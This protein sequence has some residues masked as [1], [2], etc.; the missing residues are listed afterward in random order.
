MET[1]LKNV[2][3]IPSWYPTKDQPYL[4]VFFKEQ[5]YL[6]SENFNICV[7]NGK[8]QLIGRKKF[9]TNLFTK[10]K[11]YSNPIQVENNNN[12]YKEFEFKYPLYVFRTEKQQL[13]QTVKFYQQALENLEFS[14]DLIHA[15]SNLMAGIIASEITNKSNCKLLITE[16]LPLILNNFNY[17]LKE[18][19]FNAL[20]KANCVS[21]VS[22]H[23]RALLI[24]NIPKTEVVNHGNLIDENL[25]TLKKELD[26]SIYKIGWVGS[27]YYRK[28]PFT[29]LR[30]VKAIQRK[31]ISCHA[32]MVFAS[33]KGEININEI[34]EFIKKEQLTDVITI[35]FNRTREELIQ[36][37]HSIE[38]LIC[39]SI[40]ETFG[41]I[42]AEAMMCGTPVISTNNGGVQD[43]INNGVNGYITNVKDFETIASH[44]INIFNNNIVFE[45]SQLRDSI[46]NKF[47]RTAFKNKMIHLY[48]QVINS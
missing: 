43:I 14:P 47:G 48:N 34:H 28:D 45:S 33:Q 20:K 6:M 5:A 11:S 41:M 2:L 30:V 8:S 19:Y 24:D 1:P 7:L 32:T 40:S 15:Q 38:T 23:T 21:T 46:L 26:N 22:E 4:G 9:I 25:F 35:Q 17:R 3:I 42:I 12:G 44:T 29:F 13:S 37:Y 31:N 36:L 27:L 16:H 39:T 18:S 10:T